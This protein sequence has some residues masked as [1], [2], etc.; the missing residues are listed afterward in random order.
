MTVS[1]LF[2]NSGIVDA[3]INYEQTL[4][5]PSLK[6]GYNIKD[7]NFLDFVKM[8]ALGSK[9]NFSFN[10]TDDE[11][12]AMYKKS[13][14]IHKTSEQHDIDAIPPAKR[15]EIRKVLIQAENSLPI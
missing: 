14:N 8:M 9:A 3:H 5:N 10:P 1:H 6:P 4:K 12:V 11:I 13:N 15:D 2:F 7:S